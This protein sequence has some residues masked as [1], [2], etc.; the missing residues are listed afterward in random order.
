GAH[1]RSVGGKSPA[2]SEFIVILV[3]MNIKKEEPLAQLTSFNVG[4]EAELLAF[5][6][7]TDEVEDICR[8]FDD[9]NLWL[10]G[11]GTNSLISDDGLPGLTI[12]VQ[13]RGIEIKKNRI[14]AQAG[15]N[16]DELVQAAIKAKLWG[17]E[18]M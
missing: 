17:V 13:N 7:H 5:L 14:T 2:I 1:P 16:W 3:L 11:E 9:D 6:S 8:L 12:V 18:L 4:G 10:L 15:T